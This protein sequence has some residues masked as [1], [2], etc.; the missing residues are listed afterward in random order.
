MSYQTSYRRQGGGP[1]SFF[2]GPL[3]PIVKYIIIANVVMFFLGIF[4][5][6]AIFGLLALVPAAV[7]PGLQLWRLGTYLFLHADFAHILFNMLTLWWF[8]GPLEQIWGPRKFLLYFFLTGIGAGAVSVPFYLL[9]GSPDAVIVGASGALYGLLMAFA[10]IYPN[11]VV[12]VF[13]MVPVKV[14][15]LVAIFMVME[16]MASASYL[17]GGRGSAVA[18]IAHL[19]GAL[20]GYFYL[21]RFMDLKA[22]YHRFRTRKIKRPYRVVSPD[23]RNRPG[24]WL[25]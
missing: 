1:M 24:P 11:S 25:H 7:Y 9:A 19:S 13:F 14:K 23:D 3:P 21:R 5:R 22:L 18:S 16:F 20:I 10:L 17:G 2:G 8:G 15:W 6:D 12:Y 4:G